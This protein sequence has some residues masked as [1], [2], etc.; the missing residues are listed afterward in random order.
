MGDA[1]VDSQIVSSEAGYKIAGLGPH[2]VNL[3]YS[4]YTVGWICALP[5]ELTA[6]TAIL[7]QIHPN[8][9]KPS[10]DPNAY[11]LG[12]I[13][14]HNIV[15]ACLPRGEISN[16]S[17]AISA[18][19]MA[20]TFPFIKFSLL[21][22]IGGG[23]PPKVS[24]GD[25]VVGTPGDEHQG[26]VE[27]DFGKA[28]DGRPFGRVGGH[29]SP[30]T[31]LLTALA[32]MESQGELW[33]YKIPQ[34]LDDMGRKWPNMVP[35]YT[36]ASCRKGHSIARIDLDLE[37]V[38]MDAPERR[39]EGMRVHYGLIASGSQA[40][41]DARFRDSLD[42]YLG[43]DVMCVETGAAGLMD[44]FPCLVIRGISN[45]ADSQTTDEWQEYAAGVAAACAKELLQYVQPSEVVGERSDQDIL[46]HVV[47]TLEII[48]SKMARNE[49]LEI[50]NWLTPI[51]Y[52]P[53]HSELIRK[54]QPGTGQWFL[55][56]DEY[57]FWR[58]SDCQ[59]LFCPGI[60]GAGKTMMTAIVIDDL[61][62]RLLQDQ[63]VGIAYIYCNF[64]HKDEQRLEDLLASLLKQLCQD[65]PFALDIVRPIH[66]KHK[67][68]QTRP[69][70]GEIMQA[71]V[72]VARI[73]SRV[74]IIVDALDEC[75]TSDGCLAGFLSQ[76]TNLQ[77][78]CG[79]NIFATS[80][81][82]PQISETFKSSTK[83]EIRAH[84]QD[85]RGYLRARVSQLQSTIL[86]SHIEDIQNSITEAADGMF[87]LAQLHFDTVKTRKTIKKVRD[88]LKSL[89]TGF[90]YKHPYNDTMQRIWE[91]DSDSQKLA[92]DTLS[93]ITYAKRPLSPT[94]LQ[95][96]LAVEHD[97]PDLGHD[98]LPQIEE[99]ISVCAGLV[100]VDEASGIIQ[101]A[102]CTI[103]EYFQQTQK[104]WFPDAETKIAQT[105]I[106]YL[107]FRAF[108]TGPCRTGW[109]LTERL[110]VYPLYD[111]A[112]CNWGHHARG[113]S[114]LFSEAV[115][116]LNSFLQRAGNDARSTFGQRKDSNALK[117]R[118]VS[119]RALLP[120]RVEDGDSGRLDH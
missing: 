3:T 117:I 84:D 48:R 80:R 101:F 116:F 67:N 61:T 114:T 71:L 102:H 6:A 2:A 88:S 98:N 22:G 58:T 11:T 66:N 4:D 34:Y 24:L 70:L 56:S 79:V 111:Y 104:H 20:R 118:D 91:L 35:A 33:G 1:G 36:H 17:I 23:I 45:Y 28:Q 8:L 38:E 94:E 69:L 19:Q 103:Q 43:G 25:V 65:R 106:S 110:H 78:Q 55:D 44:D 46:G 93:W 49:D 81:F 51:D 85:I 59:T 42:E 96:A 74:F 83:L 87:L 31:A 12:S 120:W 16:S 77:A 100:T 109:D 57:C 39:S 76:L 90:A 14:K 112:T 27:W 75:Q 50:L 40:V 7:D 54:R 92:R 52:G 5:R 30:P 95:H 21:V 53:R 86:A 60:P 10:D 72:S 37:Q 62:T 115:E 41:T 26:V 15:I 18:T 89:P 113:A 64:R 68:K 29:N 82:I 32:K 9:P 107:S 73:Y 108:E 99:A 13:G 119:G 105:C 97:E 47:G 63:S